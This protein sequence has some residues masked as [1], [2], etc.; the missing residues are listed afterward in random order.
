ML[1]L[2]L[3]RLSSTPSRRSPATIRYNVP[4][5]SFQLSF[6]R[7]P[8][9]SSRLRA[10]ETP[11]RRQSL[12]LGIGYIYHSCGALNAPRNSIAIKLMSLFLRTT[13]ASCKTQQLLGLRLL[14]AGFGLGLEFASRSPT[15]VS[16][17]HGGWS[18]SALGP[19]ATRPGESIQP[20]HGTPVSPDYA[21]A[22]AAEAAAGCGPIK[23]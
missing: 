18:G 3:L 22:G 1:W 5:L 16:C 9:F 10:S 2:N 17:A 23:R 12:F 7:A 21:A 13:Q 15:S 20:P 6:T 4:F 11:N 14:R 8:R 19:K